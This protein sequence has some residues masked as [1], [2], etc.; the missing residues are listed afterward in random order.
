MTGPDRVIS[1][2]PGFTIA[3]VRAHWDGVVELYDRVNEKIGYGHRQRFL[4]GLAYF[5]CTDNPRLLN[6]WS[7]ICEAV[8]YVYERF[9]AGRL[10][11]CEASPAMVARARHCFPD[12]DIRL[13][14][15]TDLEL[16][17]E[18]FDA[19]LSLECIEHCPDPYRFVCELFRVLGPGGELVLSCPS[20]TAEPMLQAYE[21]FFENHGEGPHRF[22]WSWDVKKM[23][24]KAGFEL[25]EHR[26]TV[27]LPVIPEWLSWLD[28]FLG[29]A[30][31]RLPVIGEIGIRQFYYCVKPGRQARAAEEPAKRHSPVPRE[32]FQRLKAEV[33]DTGLCHCCGTCAGVC[34]HGV[35]RMCDQ[36]SDCLPELIGDCSDCDDEC[37]LGCS[38]KY[39]DF[40]MLNKVL[41]GAQ[42]ES[43]LLGNY[44][45]L[46]VAHATDEHIRRE[47]A[48]GGVVTAVVK[49]LFDTGRIEGAYVMGMDPQ[50]PYFSKSYLALSYEQAQQ[51]SGS[52]YAVAP[53]NVQLSQISPEGPPLCYVGLPCQVHSL[54]KLQHAGHRV[55]RRFR[56]VVGPY[57]GNIL[58]FSSTR[59]FLNKHGVYDMNEVV[60]LAYRAGEWPGNLRVELRSGRIIE[61]PKFHANYLIPF[62]IMKRCLLC[63]DMTNEFTDISGG[64]AWAPVYEERGKGFSMMVVRTPI[65]KELTDEM[66]REGK[67]DVTP[68]SGEDTVAMHSHGLDLKKRGVF[69]R[70]RR[71]KVIRK[72][73]PN[74][75]FEL[76]PGVPVSRR[77]MEAV[78]WLIFRFCWT[79]LGR[80]LIQLVPNRL[81]S[82]VFR[83]A[84][85]QW[86]S[87]TCA[88]K[89]TGL[90]TIRFVVH[91]PGGKASQDWK[92]S[93]RDSLA[94]FTGVNGGDSGKVEPATRV[95]NPRS[96]A[97]SRKI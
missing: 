76:A 47:G 67:L 56:Y 13:T 41:H 48:S 34:P 92:E 63:A 78:M 88:T 97:N 15:L 24:R 9:P 11:H 2:L 10:V 38:G 57:C 79:E 94:G 73:V 51:A 84:R 33:I 82:A 46:W 36:L 95:R 52:K 74:Y 28:Q 53:H 59:S 30:L 25:I 12:E 21:M 65:G 71:R 4:H 14:D 26:G 22:P 66:I 70:I 20:A 68:I 5:Q 23:L 93:R 6:I 27:F 75:G 89:R 16:E 42:P 54:R 69:L 90:G 32:A 85:T 62:Y 43:Y 72:A 60:C 3:Q 29:K 50:R 64:D 80:E 1:A 49:H 91:R 83:R 86:K 35:L 37:H 81:I 96:G 39:V 18:S 7:R 44:C 45:D 31:G 40:P 8:P 17:S 87:A 58:R 77:V 55:A 19:V 61:I